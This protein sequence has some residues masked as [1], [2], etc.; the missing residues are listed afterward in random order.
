MSRPR[1]RK[2]EVLVDMTKE[3]VTSERSHLQEDGIPDIDNV[4][5]SL[6]MGIAYRQKRIAHWDAIAD[7]T[8]SRWNL[9]GYYHDR[10]KEIF[11]FLVPPG[12]KVLELGCQKGD[13]LAALEPSNGV[14]VDFSQIMIQSAQQRHPRLRFVQMDVHELDLG[15]T[16]DVIILSDL[17]NDIW[18]VQRVFQVVRQHSAPHTRIIINIYSHLWQGPLTLARMMKLANPVMPQNWLTP[19]DVFQLLELEGLELIRHWQ[20]VLVPIRLPLL[21]TFFNKC[22]TRFWPF[23][24]FA[25]ANFIIARPQPS[26][27]TEPSTKPVVSVIVAARNEAGNIQA[28]FDRVPRMGVGTELI[29]VEGGS[30]DNTYESIEKAIDLHPEQ[31]Q[32]RLYR[33]K[34]RG[35]GDAVRLGFEKATGD[36]LMILDADLT[37]APEDLPLFYKALRSGHG[38]FINGVRLVY[39]MEDDAMRFFNVLGNKFFS[40]A[41]S[42]VLGQPIKDTLCGTKVL[43]KANYEKIAENRSYFGNFDPFGDF[44]LI[45][46]AAKL[47]MKMVDLPIRYRKRLYGDTNIKRWSHGW[48]LLKMVLFSLLRIKLV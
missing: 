30:K 9:S 35:K 43:T 15:R 33:Q 19:E 20:E 1:S 29:F 34:G 44:D 8:E 22:I 13:L 18:N 7:M 41:F 21:S 4:V 27:K 39:P 25:L 5:R 45:F 24:H 42:W 32:A 40:M 3:A 46:G 10:L 47:N 23:R 28:I 2:A 31:Q 11:C 48:L 36:I 17:L 12:Q 16:F 38:E 26:A 37:V 6:D 14:G